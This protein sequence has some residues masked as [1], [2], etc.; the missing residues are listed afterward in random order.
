MHRLFVLCC[1]L[2]LWTNACLLACS[3]PSFSTKTLHWC[4]CLLYGH[5]WTRRWLRRPKSEAQIL[6]QWGQTGPAGVAV[7]AACLRARRSPAA[8]SAAAARL[9][10]PVAHVKLDRTLS[11]ASSFSWDSGMLHFL[12]TD[13]MKWNEVKCNKYNNSQLWFA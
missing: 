10:R 9:F 1:W 6:P 3:S 13:L 12:S 4:G 5:K 8:C 11:S 7:A 2:Y